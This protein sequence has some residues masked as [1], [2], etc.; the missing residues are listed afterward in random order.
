[1]APCLCAQFSTSMAAGAR[2]QRSTFFDDELRISDSV[3]DWACIHSAAPR[4]TTCAILQEAVLCFYSKFQWLV[5]DPTCK[6]TLSVMSRKGVCR[7][8]IG[9]KSRRFNSTRTRIE[10]FLPPYGLACPWPLGP[11]PRDLGRY[12]YERKLEQINIWI[13]GCLNHHHSCWPSEYGLHSDDSTPL[14]KR[15][16]RLD[17]RFLTGKRVRLYEPNGK[18]GRYVCLSHRWGSSQPLKTTFG[19]LRRHKNGIPWDEIP[20]TFQGAIT[21]ALELGIRYVWIDSLC[22]VQDDPVDWNEQSALMCDIYQ[23]AWLTIAASNGLGCHDELIPTYKHVVEAQGDDGLQHVSVGLEHDHLFSNA[24]EDNGLLSRGWVMQER[25]LSRRVLYCHHDEL[26]WECTQSAACE[27]PQGNA[28]VFDGLKSRANR[29]PR[30]A[31]AVQLQRSWQRT[32]THY[33]GLNLSRLKDRQVAILGLAGEMKPFRKGR[34]LAGLWEDNLL[35][36]LAW[37]LDYPEPTSYLETQAPSWSW[38]STIS[39]CHFV[40]WGDWHNVSGFTTS[41]QKIDMPPDAKIPHHRSSDGSDIAAA[42]DMTLRAAGDFGR[43][44]FKAELVVGELFCR[45]QTVSSHDWLFV[46]TGGWVPPEYNFKFYAD[47]AVPLSIVVALVKL[48]EHPTAS[49]ALAL[50]LV[51][52]SDEHDLCRR[53]GLVEIPFDGREQLY[54]NFAADRVVEVI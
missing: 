3:I 50:E 34:Y 5:Q 45:D 36:D 10:F 1:M 52:H 12:N 30:N 46:R 32:V 8:F 20:K 9:T 15:V 11:P 26:I 48:G 23:N 40:S 29:L 13:Q 27:C 14:P 37:Y 47:R 38:A 7:A 6:F 43:L 4:C 35:L 22:I 16:L 31:S 28:V 24:S 19:N 39:R 42:K 41:I 2:G 33:S 49:Y 53:V 54:S 44:R 18:A 51:E 25:C 17:S 21:L